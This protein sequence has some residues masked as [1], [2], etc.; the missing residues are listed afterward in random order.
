MLN[1]GSVPINKQAN[2]HEARPSS[3]RSNLQTG[4]SATP[5]QYSRTSLQFR[6]SIVGNNS[7]VTVTHGQ[8]DIQNF[9]QNPDIDERGKV[10]SIFNARYMISVSQAYDV[11]YSYTYR[12]TVISV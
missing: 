11:Y 6:S 9:S 2:V 5:I 3:L 7:T 12:H 8:N 1:L 4:L 10:N